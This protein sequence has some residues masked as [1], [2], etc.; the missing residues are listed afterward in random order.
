MFFTLINEFVKHFQVQPQQTQPV[1]EEQRIAATN[2]KLKLVICS[3]PNDRYR[4]ATAAPSAAPA[5]PR[6]QAGS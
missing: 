2:S 5:G 6:R 4:P 3:P 1:I